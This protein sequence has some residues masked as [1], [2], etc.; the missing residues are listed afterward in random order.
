MKRVAVLGAGPAG[1]MAAARLAASGLHTTLIDEKPPW[2]K[3]CG[4]GVTFKAYN[5]YPFLLHNDTAKRVVHHTWLHAPKVGGVRMDLNQPL[6]IYSRK[7]LNAMLLDRAEKAGVEIAIER[8]AAIDRTSRGW[9]IRTKAGTI[10]TDYVVVATG[11]RNSLKQFGT[12]Y[13]A[14]D[15]MYALGYYV[16]TDRHQIDIQFLENLEGYIW[17]FP[18]CGHLSV[19]I[20]G[21]GEPAQALR[22]RLEAYMERNDLPL[23]DA[24]F[25]GH[26][27][28]SL[29]RAGWQ[30]NRVSGDRWV[31][32]GDAA[33]LVDPITGEGIYYAMRSGDLAGEL[34]G[35]DLEDPA[36]HADSYR[37]LI[38]REFTDDLA[39][40]STIAKRV[41]LGN[42]LFG[43][44]PSRMV[45]FLRRSP[46]FTAIMQ[47]VFAGTITY[48]DLRRR[49][50]SNINCS[51]T[52]IAMNILLGR[53]PSP[54]VGI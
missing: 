6:V 4:G 1:S 36:Q 48:F 14:A 47:E 39:Y 16:P 32:V 8:V 19:G 15:T 53:R 41:F 25:Y 23:K 18:R 38:A 30:N 10:E 33:G 17:V 20:C 28:P 29:E 13:T 50:L 49:L 34:I 43:S 12:S 24:T 5:Q 40:G 46:G 27:L 9:D 21:K 45:Q 42:F 7:D 37:N 26:M 2:E 54:S 51:V 52:E 31:A 44:N 11:A 22:A 35:S 3:P